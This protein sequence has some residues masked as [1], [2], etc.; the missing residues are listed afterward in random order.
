MTQEAIQYTETEIEDHDEPTVISYID[1]DTIK[2]RLNSNDP[3]VRL[4]AKLDY[5]INVTAN[6]ADGMGTAMEQIQDSP[7]GRMLGNALGI[8]S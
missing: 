2:D 8:K 6:M 7:I 1:V 5:V 4:E 3:M